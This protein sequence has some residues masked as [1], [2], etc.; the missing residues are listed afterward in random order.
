MKTPKE[1]QVLDRIRTP[2]KIAPS[3]TSDTVSDRP[4]L[5]DTDSDSGY[6]GER[7]TVGLDPHQELNT[8]YDVDRVVSEK[9]AGLGAGLDQAEEARLG[10]TDEEIEE[11]EADE[12]SVVAKTPP[13]RK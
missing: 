7:A 3:D 2:A 6:T 5:P 11:D 8:E 4:N 12:D 13:E 1:D 9:D 10:T